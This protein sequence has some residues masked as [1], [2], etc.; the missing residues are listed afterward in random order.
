MTTTVRSVS[1]S[2]AG[3]PAFPPGSF[4]LLVAILV[5]G[6]IDVVAVPVLLREQA[7]DWRAYDEAARAIAAHASLY[8]WTVSADVRAVTDY[9]YLYPPPLALLWS[10]GLTPA[11]YAVLK[12]LSVV[13]VGAFARRA[14][15]G[16]SRSQAGLAALA[17]IALSLASPPVIHDLVLGNVMVLYL[18]ASA[19][20]VA[21]PRRRLAAAPLGVLVAVALK[22]AL[23]PLLLWLLIRRRAQFVTA[24]V[25]GLVAT[26]IA[27][28]F[29][30]VG[31]YVDYLLALPRMGGLAQAFT[32]N[33]GLSAVSLPVALAA[34]PAGLAWT[35]W[36]SLRLS[37]WSAAAVALGMT[38]LVQPK[39]GLN[40]SA[41]LIPAVIALWFVD[42]RWALVAAVVV[43]FAALL[44]PPLG[45]L[46]VAAVATVADVR[47][48]PS[49]TAV[50]TPAAS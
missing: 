4:A 22:P 3:R 31:S 7:T 47:A 40:Y 6:A 15:T 28:V 44:S 19:L 21:F 45:G 27:L 25:A 38:Q 10:L 35:A 33:L 18:A 16:A 5:L 13:T 42:R 39:L 41:L 26:A 32:G 20:V 36:S 46:L 34:V 14:L 8:P 11:L 1:A 49:V 43:P 48:R 12:A 30:G 23:A 37:D 17:L 2:I 50:A 24:F 9:P 29:V